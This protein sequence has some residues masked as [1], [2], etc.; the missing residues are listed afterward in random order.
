MKVII[1]EPASDK[2]LNASADTETAPVTIP[3]KNLNANNITLHIIPT[4]P[5]SIPYEALTS[6]SLI[7]SQS[8]INSFINNFVI[9]LFLLILISYIRLCQ[10][11][12]IM[13]TRIVSCFALPQ[14]YI[15]I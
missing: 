5:E 6:G 3:A 10:N 1:E 9:S 7:L 14:S 13:I 8:L 15:V 11:T 2:L 4:T 12:I